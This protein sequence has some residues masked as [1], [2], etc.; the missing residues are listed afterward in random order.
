MCIKIK[1]FLIE[2]VPA[3]EQIK[4]VAHFE[5][6]ACEIELVSLQLTCGKLGF[7]TKDIDLL[8]H[9]SINIYM[10]TVTLS[11]EL[12]NGDK[13]LMSEIEKLRPRMS[14]GKKQICKNIDHGVWEL[15]KLLQN[16]YSLM[17]KRPDFVITMSEKLRLAILSLDEILFSL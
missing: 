10:A 14:L 11:R 8:H 5:L 17:S 3:I 6:R 12:V 15:K 4:D 13:N 16:G 1:K 2:K 7:K 9:A